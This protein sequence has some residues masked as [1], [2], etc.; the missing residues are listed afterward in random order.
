MAA[1]AA[2]LPQHIAFIPDGNRRWARLRGLPTLRGHQIGF[3]MGEKIIEK[4]FGLGVK[5]VTLWAFSTE[6]WNRSIEE[7]TYLMRLYNLMA[8][9]LRR[10][11]NKLG[12]RINVIG[13]TSPLPKFLQQSLKL[14][15]N[16]TKNNNKMIVN[17]A[18]NYGSRDEIVR[19]TQQLLKKGIKPEE[20]TQEILANELDTKGQPDPDLIV[21]TSGEHRLSGFML[22]QAAY[23]E[24]YFAPVNWP[25]FNEIELEKALKEYSRRQRRFGK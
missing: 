17:I 25:D 2:I 7:V 20:V 22:W 4:C 23:S 18:L 5:Y 9:R 3:R 15:A 12:I 19:A 8:K 10:R 24:L 6:N 1:Q 13:D 11:L 16:E 14:A 21:R